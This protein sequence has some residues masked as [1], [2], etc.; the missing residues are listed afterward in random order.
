VSH[1]NPGNRVSYLACD[2]G[3]W[4]SDGILDL[5]GACCLRS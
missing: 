1:P 5:N 4:A 3:K 2:Q